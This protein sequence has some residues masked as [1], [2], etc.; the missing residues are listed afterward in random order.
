MKRTNNEPRQ[1]MRTVGV[2]VPE[3]IW[4]ELKEAA[5]D[6]MRKHPGRVTTVSDVIRERLCAP[7]KVRIKT[8]R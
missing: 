1:P 2:K 6:E 4:L 5:Q 7:G 8:K 3:N